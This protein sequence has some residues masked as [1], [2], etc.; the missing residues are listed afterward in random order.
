MSNTTKLLRQFLL[1]P[2]AA[3]AIE[4]S[5]VAAGV[6]LAVAATV[7]S[8]GSTLKSTFYDRLLGLM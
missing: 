2:C 6:G 5:M 1:D 8:I 7:M 3:T 4:Y